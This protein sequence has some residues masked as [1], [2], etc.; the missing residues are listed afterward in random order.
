VGQRRSLVSGAAQGAAGASAA[1]VAPGAPGL[2]AQPGAAGTGANTGAGGSTSSFVVLGAS[3]DL[4]EPRPSRN[5]PAR[6]PRRRGPR[7]SAPPLVRVRRGPYPPPQPPLPPGPPLTVPSTPRPAAKKKIFPALFALYYGGY[8]PADLQLVGYARSKMTDEEFRERLLEYLSCRVEG[9]ADCGTKMEAFLSRVTYVS[10]NY[11]SEEDF[12]RL[13]EVLAGHEEGYAQAN[14][15]FYLSLPPSVFLVACQ[16]LSAS[17]SSPSG[18]TRVIV[19]KPFGKDLRSYQA[20]D[21]GMKECL[22]EDQ[23]FR[24][25]H[26]LGKELVENLSVLR[27]SNSIFEPLWNR[28]HIRN[29][30]VTFTEDFGTEG[31]GGYYDDFGVVRDII[32]NHILQV[33]SLFAM[34]QPVSLEAEDVRNEKVKV[35]RSIQPIRPEDVVLG[36]YKSCPRSNRPGYLDDDTVPAGSTT[37]T[38]AAMAMFISNPRWDGVPFMIRAGKALDRRVGEIRIQFRHVPGN[39]FQAR[40]PE[41]DQNTNELVIRIQPDEEI[42]MKINNKL[43][44][45]GLRISTTK[46]DLVYRDKFSKAQAPEAYERLIL[47]ALNGD[48]RLFI[49]DDELQKAWE[50]FTPLLDEIEGSP[51]QPELYPYGSQGPV[52]AHYLAARYN[53]KPA[54]GD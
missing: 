21:A 54:G 20:L 37:P 8:L 19:E 47:D 18:W 28:D 4:G 11:D 13:S 29:V 53:I 38:F 35:L 33:L 36:Q 45:M 46:L 12:A 15:M 32:Q 40:Y 44:G 25:D 39:M 17:A 1:K 2:S 43:P 30:Q 50:L 49:R 14:R 31:R 16:A 26:Y 10:G 27:F 5:S 23:I 3:G 6:H 34:E 24:I 22:R 48:R 9:G 41:L 51:K 42:F 7:P 52:G